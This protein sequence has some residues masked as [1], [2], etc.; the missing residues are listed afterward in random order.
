MFANFEVP[1]TKEFQ[2]NIIYV[3]PKSCQL[4]VSSKV[5]A[6]PLRIQAQENGKTEP[7]TH[8]LLSHLVCSRGMELLALFL[9]PFTKW[10]AHFPKGK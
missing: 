8:F 3:V 4:D 7:I 2:L 6:P 1:P 9:L 5:E 10:P